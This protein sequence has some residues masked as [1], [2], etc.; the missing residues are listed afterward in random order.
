MPRRSGCGGARSIAARRDGAGDVVAPL[1]RDLG[2][3]L[4]MPHDVETVRMVLSAQMGKAG[5][6][7][8]GRDLHAGD[9]D[10]G[11][12]AG[13]GAADDRDAHGRRHGDGVRARRLGPRRVVVRRRRRLVTRRV[14][15]GHQPLRRPP[16]A[17]DVLRGEQPDR[18]LDAGG[19]AVRR[20]CLCRQGRRL[21]HPRHHASMAPI[22][23]RSPR[24]LRGRGARARRT[25][26]DAHR[27][28]RMRMC[29]HA[30]HDDML[31]LGRDPQASWSYPALTD[32]ATRIASLRVT[33]PPAIRSSPMRR[34]WRR[35]A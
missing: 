28:G 10:V 32:P 21:R 22:P 26:S 2:V 7:M 18:A 16:A 35:K 31:Y 34:G 14:A 1:I 13:R 11:H 15:R 24:R 27:V 29:G 8:N 20:P 12:P 9:F 23:T 3:V 33:G 25:W 17:C 6:P 5:P 19:R 4:A 30:H